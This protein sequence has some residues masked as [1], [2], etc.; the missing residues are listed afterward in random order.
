MRGITHGIQAKKYPLWGFIL[1]KN[2]PYEL[3]FYEFTANNGH[4]AQDLEK[5]IPPMSQ[6]CGTFV[7]K[8]DKNGEYSLDLSENNGRCIAQNS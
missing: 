2:T 8:I 7:S 4:Y 5:K 6:K 1:E 3:K